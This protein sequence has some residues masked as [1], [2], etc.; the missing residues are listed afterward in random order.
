MIRF[1]RE[2]DL[3]ERLLAGKQV[4]LCA[5]RWFGKHALAR[6]I[7][8]RF[9][10]A[11]W[12]IIDV[13]S[14]SRAGT[15][16]LE[17]GALWADV[18]QSLRVQPSRDEVSDAVSFE[19]ALVQ[20][21][22]AV[23]T[24]LLVTLRGAG[25]DNLD[26]HLELATIIH[27][28]LGRQRRKFHTA[29]LVLDDHSLA[30]SRPSPD[31]RSELNSFD[32]VQWGSLSTGEVLEAIQGQK[33]EVP[34]PPKKRLTIARALQQACGGH[35]GLL[36][37]LWSWVSRTGDWTHEKKWNKHPRW[38]DSHILGFLR[39]ALSEDVVGY[40]ATAMNYV[41]A[42]PIQQLIH[43]DVL[44][45][46]G[47]LESVGLTSLRLRGGVTKDLIQELANEHGES[48]AARLG[49]VV[50]SHGPR[51][52]EEKELKLSD[53][54]FVVVH[55]SDLHVVDKHRFRL[56]WKGGGRNPDEASL[57]DLLAAD[58]AA[59]GLAGRVD[60]IVASGD[61]T[62]HASQDEFQRAKDAMK[63]IAAKLGVPA[64]QIA[65]IPGNHDVQWEAGEF[66]EAKRNGASM[67][68]YLAFAELL[69]GLRPE[70]AGVIRVASRSGKQSLLLVELDSNAVEGR[71]AAG[72]G[73][74]SRESLA[75]A[76]ELVAK[77]RRAS[78]VPM[79]V[80][81]IVHHHIF[82]ASSARYEDAEMRRVSVM[83][84]A[85]HVLTFAATWGAELILHGHEHQP[86]V[87]VAH[88][89]PVDAGRDFRQMAVLGAGSVGVKRDYTGPISTNHYFV[90]IG[91]KTDTIVR[92]RRL[93][94][95][96]VS[97][98]PH[99]DIQL[100]R[101]TSAERRSGK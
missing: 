96:G 47:I 70:S 22:E 21:I 63:D 67:E 44:F 53:D 101:P 60:A 84:N 68:N 99:E 4:L 3:E 6:D 85:S 55:F 46:L 19:S 65:I 71:D 35:P 28:V 43:V 73:F 88:Q 40:T 27:R 9:R 48:A 33:A 86:Q 78:S 94:D 59:I 20:V 1:G 79:R 15:G 64:A 37:E 11:G 66:A 80:W 56:T 89:W 24:N 92:S 32:R 5:P 54:D 26:N 17:Y 76:S 100:P 16:P 13:S 2:V 23:K 74:V 83:A 52:W 29:A 50:R 49:S 51:V 72:I 39:R 69:R 42:Q 77:E 41:K 8:R 10:A 7:E 62:W 82:P 61:F 91:R 30:Y 58:V 90:I 36:R 14:R 45:Q 87:H 38:A 31:P 75:L 81:A 18:G 34:I 97:F 95:E 93:G 12:S 25:R 57:A 98:I